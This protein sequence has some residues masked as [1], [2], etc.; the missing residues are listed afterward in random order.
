MKRKT[1]LA[2]ILILIAIAS[3]GASNIG[4]RI[5]E[6]K[7]ASTEHFDIIYKDQNQL[8]ASLIFNNCEEIYQS[9][10]EFFQEDPKL[11]IPVV[12]TS[13]YKDLNAYYTNY[14]ANHI[15]LYDTVATPGELSNFR[16]TILYI[17]RHELSHAFQ[18]NI[19]GS[20]FDTLHVVFGDILTVAPIFY[21]YPSLTEGGAV[22]A[23]SADGAG[24][25]NN[26][27]SMQ[28]VKQ[29]KIEGLFPNWFEIAG[30]RDTY[31]SGLLY[32]NFAACFLE[33]LSQTY[34]R[35][36]IAGIFKDFRGWRWMATPGQVI[37]EHIGKTVQEAW[38]DFYEW[39]QIPEQVTE[40][41]EITKGRF[42]AT[43]ASTT[44]G[45]T[46]VYTFDSST[47]SVYR[48]NEDL[49]EKKAILTL[50]TEQPSLSISNDGTL[51]L[52]PYVDA[53]TSE[54]RIYDIT[55]DKAKLAKTYRSED[56]DFRDGTFV[57]RNGEETILLY[58]NRGQNT[59]LVLTGNNE[60]EK[61]IS[62]GF[63]VTASDFTPIGDNKVAFLATHGTLTLITIL[64][65]ESGTLTALENPDHLRF[66]N[67]GE[68]QTTDQNSNETTLS[69]T[70]YPYDAESS[71]LGRYGELRTNSEA[72]E[73]TITLST[74]D[75]NGSI[76]YPLRIGDTIIFSARNYQTLSLRKIETTELKFDDPLTA[77]A[78]EF[79][80]TEDHDTKNLIESS[81]NYKAIKYFFD[82][83][84]LPVASITLGDDV[85]AGYGIT[86]VTADPTETYT[87]S[88]TA[89]YSPE[90]YILGSYSFSSTNFFPYSVTVNVAKETGTDALIL[91]AQATAS[92]TF[93]LRHQGEKLTIADQYD[94][95]LLSADKEIET[96]QR[97][98]LDLNYTYS[99]KRGV[100]VY[101]K[102]TFTA[103]AYLFNQFP[104]IQLGIQ[105]PRLLWWRCQGA[106]ITNLPVSFRADACFNN[107]WDD[108]S[109][110]AKTKVI[111]YGRELQWSFSF[112][113]LYFQRFTLSAQ[114][115]ANYLTKDKAFTHTI[116]LSALFSLSP[117]VGSYLTRIKAGLGATATYK[118]QTNEWVFNVAFDMSM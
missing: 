31:P 92:F 95:L 59:Y 85:E 38:N 39:V 56:I 89:G 101:E 67:L 78:T 49:T 12:I 62:L 63:D 113:G 8:T 98:I 118:P 36:N 51:L 13:A 75:I 29:A 106:D 117:I 5:G 114:Y 83:V 87:H 96:A 88:I 72:K 58:G 68:V 24:R 35:E 30:A 20:F 40:T 42:F 33:Y 19:R 1:L 22:L 45:Q 111:L 4:G 55:H 50:P 86:W 84:L 104:G 66:M 82:G 23:E 93:N 7:T 107:A 115:N 60:T 27:Y 10:V 76:E 100:G 28:V 74:T 102:F 71:N 15:V 65:L 25:I 37:Y 14:P 103:D 46:T 3:I 41:E 26:S 16:Q 80:K 79:F 54:V 94:F 34:G 81:R 11:T 64:D 44:D 69:F 91:G 110:T 61:E 97:N 43:T 109:L 6:A 21:L 9:L 77:K 99:I 105:L 70:W 48:L 47:A 73:T 57:T 90:G 52:I 108:I 2:A 116:D 17:F 112:F 53:N 32:Y 18:H